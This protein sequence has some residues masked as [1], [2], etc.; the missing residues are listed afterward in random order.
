[1]SDFCHNHPSGNL[2][3]SDANKKITI[4]LKEA[5]TVMEIPVIDHVIVAQ[6]GYFSFSD[7]G[8]LYRK[9][10]KFAIIFQIRILEYKIKLLDLK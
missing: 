10:L 7:E 4:Q 8:M 1:L 5:A 6:S 2:K 3:P 9:T